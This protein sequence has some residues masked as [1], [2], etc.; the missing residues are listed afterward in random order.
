MSW[1]VAIPDVTVEAGE[2]PFSADL[3]HERSLH[4]SAWRE[5]ACGRFIASF[6]TAASEGRCCF[7]L[8]HVVCLAGGRGA[9]PVPFECYS[10]YVGAA[11]TSGL[12]E[13]GT[14]W[15]NLA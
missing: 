7:E 5:G 10:D 11:R 1:S 3:N 4:Y 15:D 6:T 2:S 13:C 14:V 8:N 9:P 12:A